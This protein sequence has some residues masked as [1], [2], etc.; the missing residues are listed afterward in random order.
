MAV[1]ADS[2]ARFGS[3]EERITIRKPLLAKPV[4]PRFLTAGDRGE[5]G[6]VVH[7]YTGKAGTAI[8]V[9]KAE[10]AWFGETTKSVDIDDQGSARVRFTTTAGER[11]AASF[12]FTVTLGDHTDGLRVSVPVNRAHI[13]D[14]KTLARGVLGGK[15]GEQSVE[16]ALTWGDDVVK[17]DSMVTITVDRGGMAELEPSLRYLVEYPHGCLEQTLS[18]FIPMTQV[19]ELAG[20]LGLA[21]LDG[22]ELARFIRAGAAK[23]ARHQDPHNGHFRLWPGSE[24]KPYLTVA[25]IYGLNEAKRAKIK[26][27]EEVLKRGVE[28]MRSWASSSTRKL[29]PDYETST[30]AMAAFLLADLGKADSGLNARLYG[31]RAGMPIYGQALLLRALHLSKAPAEQIATLTKELLG[32]VVVEETTASVKEKQNDYGYFSSNTRSTAITLSALLE[33]DPDN[34]VVGKLVE[35]LVRAQGPGGRWENTQDNLYALVALAAYARRQRGGAATVTVS[36]NGKQLTKQ[37]LK[38]SSMVVMRHP[39]NTMA[40]KLTIAS[41]GEARYSVRV[42]EVRK[43]TSPDPVARGLSVTREYLCPTT[44]RPL[45][46]FAANQLVTVRLTVES[47]EGHHYIVVSDPLPAGFE[48]VNTR[49]ATEAAADD[50]EDEYYE[51]YDYY[52]EDE[53]THRELRD[54]RFVAF[55]DW[56]ESGEHTLEYQA[57]VTLPGKF[58]VLPAHAEAMYQPTINGRTGALEV[59]IKR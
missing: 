29:G 39:A 57:R 9:G 59:K 32:N 47:E 46:R 25:A 26:I 11:A 41:K 3:G 28:A 1:A 8:V 49:L 33:V 13:T 50:D 53:W 35:G 55:A 17:R 58:I 7:N 45:T 44:G 22:P 36:H 18:K 38:G 20:S 51:D 27:D 5:L 19:K 56:L 2:G 52:E 42:A 14:H 54:D 31:A 21:A 10:G 34:P 16:V 15:G 30:V 37:H 48:A 40:G 23:V 12:E 4:V 24:S 43:D 6:V